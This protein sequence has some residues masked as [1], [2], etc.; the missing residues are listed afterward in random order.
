MLAEVTHNF[1]QDLKGYLKFLDDCE[2]RY[3]FGFEGL[4]RKPMNKLWDLVKELPGFVRLRADRSV[5]ATY[6][7]ELKTLNSGWRC[8]SIHYSSE[9]TQEM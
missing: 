7:L 9:A 6:P 4:G 1:P 8:P 2:K 5:Y 3:V